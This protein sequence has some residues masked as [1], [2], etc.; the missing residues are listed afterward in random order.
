M[1]GSCEV[2]QILPFDLAQAEAMDAA[3]DQV[4]DS[5]TQAEAAGFARETLTPRETR[6]VCGPIR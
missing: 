6:E 4:E 2:S 1:V 3:H 5:P